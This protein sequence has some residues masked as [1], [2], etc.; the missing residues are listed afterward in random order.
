MGSAKCQIFPDTEMNPVI[1]LWGDDPLES[2]LYLTSVGVP[3]A[4]AQLQ[5]KSPGGSDSEQ[6]ITTSAFIWKGPARA[7]HRLQRLI[8]YT[9]ILHNLSSKYSIYIHMIIVYHKNMIREILTLLATLSLVEE[10]CLIS[11]W[12]V[13][14]NILRQRSMKRWGVCDNDAATALERFS[15]NCHPYSGWD[16]QYFR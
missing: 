5:Y 2:I 16:V 11:Q 9:I 13:V 8:D 1:D 7:V 14:S 15:A 10:K 6:N 4:E 12:T 3:S